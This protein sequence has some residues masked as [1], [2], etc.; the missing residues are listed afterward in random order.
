M[1]LAK[2]IAQRLSLRFTMTVTAL[3]GVALA[4]GLILITNALHDGVG[5]VVRDSDARRVAY[6]LHTP[7]C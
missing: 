7:R 3:L 5:K 2:G 6:E 4:A 1:R